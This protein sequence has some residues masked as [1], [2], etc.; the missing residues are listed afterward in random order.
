[1]PGPRAFLENAIDSFLD[2][3]SVVAHFPRRQ[4]PGFLEALHGLVDTK[5]HG[6]W[7]VYLIQPEAETA[8][9]PLPYLRSL[10]TP[11][12]ATGPTTSPRNLLEDPA[13]SGMLLLGALCE[14][15]R[16]RTWMQFVADYGMSCRGLDPF[17]R[18]LFCLA[19]R[20]LERAALPRTDVA[21]SVRS[22]SGH[23]DPLDMRLFVAAVLRNGR[24][25]GLL[26]ETRVG[27]VAELAGDDPV[28]A[29]LLAERSLEEVLSPFPALASYC[30]ELSWTG[31]ES[32]E[33]QER[34]GVI[35]S[36][37][38]ARHRHSAFLARSG[39]VRSITR[40]VWKGQVRAVFPHIEECRAR[41]VEES[42]AFLPAPPFAT[43][44][45]VIDDILDLEIGALAFHLNNGSNHR[46][47]PRARDATI[48]REARN[49]LAHLEVLPEPML[50]CLA[51]IRL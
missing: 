8:A 9:E 45:G 5:C 31:S 18:P 42:K 34:L 40:R 10:F 51:Q 38:G 29:S 35:T 2:G 3:A 15:E 23:V 11:G 33:E 36:I 21:L 25:P 48:L 12:I 30:E 50:R 20:G 39:D 7:D 24:E 1:M 46:R 4:S 49:A 13:F 43:D 28:L 44:Q 27:V 41:L 19:V 6:R 32:R 17:K 37:G 16:A 22:W 47:P 14:G 26:R